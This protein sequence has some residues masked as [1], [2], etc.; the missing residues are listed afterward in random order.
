MS[1]NSRSIVAGIVN[2]LA[3]FL[4][5]GVVSQCFMNKKGAT[6]LVVANAVSEPAVESTLPAATTKR[7]LRHK[8]K[9]DCIPLYPTVAPTK[10]KGG[11]KAPTV[12]PARRKLQGTAAPTTGKG[13][14]VKSAS[15]VSYP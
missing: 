5:V 10:G 3:V 1:I 4:L 9:S 7:D 12:S 14:S 6:T 13:K 11:S 2:L 15:P 8:G